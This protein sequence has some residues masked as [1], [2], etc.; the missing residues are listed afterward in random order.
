M[1]EVLGFI[2]QLQVLPKCSMHS[3]HYFYSVL[4]CE[5]VKSSLFQTNNNGKS[6]NIN[7]IKPSHNVFKGKYFSLVAG[8]AKVFAYICK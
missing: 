2:K 4:L 1:E 5:S 8:V 6:G 3:D 7:W